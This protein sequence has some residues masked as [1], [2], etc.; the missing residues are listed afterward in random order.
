[1]RYA[2]I[3]DGYQF[4]YGNM[5]SYASAFRARGVEPVAVMSTPEPIPQYLPRWFSEKFAAVHFYDGDFDALVALV[6]QY[7]PICIIPGQEVGVEMAAA[8]LEVLMP[9]KGNLPGTAVSHRDKGEMAWALE[10]AGVPSLRTIRSA[11]PQA[12]EAWVQRNSLQD[13]A[14]VVKPPKSG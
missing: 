3:V 9:E 8:L 2:V 7:D 11:D 6:K 10:R 4:A 1:V 14:L 12:I 5:P 13:K